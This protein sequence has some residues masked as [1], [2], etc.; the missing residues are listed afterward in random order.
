MKA[1]GPSEGGPRTLS[2]C[3][4]NDTAT[5]QLAGGGYKDQHV[6]HVPALPTAA[7]AVQVVY[8]PSDC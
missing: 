3:S 4:I 2:M 6:H 1:H 8:R 5:S 7:C